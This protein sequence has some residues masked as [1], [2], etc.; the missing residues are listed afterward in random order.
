[1]TMAMSGLLIS[2][3]IG[4][5]LLPPRPQQHRRYMYLFMI[6]QWALTP[7]SLLLFSA[8]PCLDA[9]THLMMGRYLGFNVSVKKRA[10]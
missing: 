2:M 10:V 3:I 4:M 6:L 9:V 1:M 8:I 5:L 7:V